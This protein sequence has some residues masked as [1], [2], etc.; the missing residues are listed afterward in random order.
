MAKEKLFTPEDFDKDPKTPTKRHG[1]WIIVALIVIFATLA[2]VLGIKRCGSNNEST[3]AGV[4]QVPITHVTDTTATYTTINSEIIDKSDSLAKRDTES[5]EIS[6]NGQN[7]EKEQ[8]PSKTKEQV[9]QTTTSNAT[10]VSD[11]ESE[12]LKVIHGDYG[13]NPERKTKLGSKYQTIQSR[14]NE[15]KREGIF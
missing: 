15:L 3:K 6:V 4:S 10:I 13:N 9:I 12:A 8:L 5:V 7:K 11:V 1:K 2:I 14:V